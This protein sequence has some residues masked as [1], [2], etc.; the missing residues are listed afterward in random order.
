[1]AVT[2]LVNEFLPLAHHAKRLVVD[3]DNL[4]WNV[5]DRANRKLLSA[6]LHT[7]ITVNGNN[8]TVRV[9]HLRPDG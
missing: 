4:D 5:V 7:A 8:Q 9:R 1:M 3:H 6:H 2:V